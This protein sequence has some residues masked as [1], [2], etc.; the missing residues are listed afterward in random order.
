MLA[1]EVANLTDLGSVAVAARPG[2][3]MLAG[4]ETCYIDTALRGAD[5]GRVRVMSVRDPARATARALFVAVALA[6][7]AAPARVQCAEP[8]ASLG[9]AAPKRFAIVIGNGDYR[10]A[11]DLR[12]A[13]AD[14]RL[15][16]D[17][18]AG[19]GYAVARIHDLDKA[20][21]E[22]M[23]QRILFEF[24]KD[25]EVVFYF[26]GHGVQIA[27]DNYLIPTDAALD[28]PYDLPFEAVSL[29]T[30]VNV[31]GA[32]ARTQ[33]VILDS[34]RANP[35]G[36]AAV[37]A[38]ISR[39]LSETGDGFNVL[40][41]PMNSLLAFSTSPGAN[42]W[43]GS[44]G[45]SPFTAALVETAREDAGAADRSDFRSGTP[46]GLQRTNGPQVPWESSTLVQSVAFG[47]P[48][49]GFALATGDAPGPGAGVPGAPTMPQ[50]AVTTPRRPAPPSAAA[51]RAMTARRDMESSG[52]ALVAADLPPRRRSPDPC[53]PRADG[54]CSS[55]GRSP[56]TRA[57]DWA[58]RAHLYPCLRSARPGR[59]AR[60]S[61]GRQRQRQLHHHGQRGC[62]GGRVDPRDRS[63][64]RRGRRPPRPRGR[65]PRLYPNEIVPEKALPACL[66]AVERFPDVGRFRYQLG[67]AQLAMRDFDAAKASF[68]RARDLGHTR[69]WVALGLLVATADARSRGSADAPVPDEAL[70]LY[71][72][73]V[74]AGDPYAIHTLGRELLRHGPDRG[75][76]ARGLPAARAGGR[77]RAYLLDERAWRLLSR[78]RFSDADPARGLRYIRKFG[79]R[80]ATSMATTT[81]ASSI[82]TGSPGW[83]PTRAAVE[84]FE[85]AAAGGHPDAPGT[86]GRLWNS[87]QLGEN[88]R[89][90]R[91][92]EWYD[93]GLARCDGWSGTNAAWI[94]VNRAPGDFTPRDAAVR[95]AKAAVLN[96][97]DSATEAQSLLATLDR[98]A[99]DG[100][101]Q[102]LVNALGGTIVVD[103]AFGPASATEMA[104]VLAAV[105]MPVPEG[106]PT[107][108]LLGLARVYWR[109][110]PCRVD[111]Y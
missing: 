32:R 9:E 111:L 82:A 19:Q 6:I 49:A 72:K 94:I 40:T 58:D 12:N 28:D 45:N 91:A 27:G 22:A 70:A 105:G 41:A 53:R 1:L 10:I 68:E 47:V 90:A 17:F 36:G 51:D 104:R 59:G 15:V 63:L 103:G 18:L 65:R 61:P 38:D 101:A 7:A 80:A 67:R 54:C 107:E 39:T 4:R 13:R 5:R 60:L 34:C 30:I 77:G 37:L 50:A 108:R 16:A 62:R 29:T 43:D 85:K 20:G 99:I 44:D 76:A 35:F 109:V 81:S 74:D 21:F 33:I 31:L 86:L 8:P 78:P 26:A 64:R 71:Q 84:W 73:G 106:T 110:E 2:I 66:A 69:A 89:Y 11:P 87:G 57:P 88:D 95:A 23:L 24:D 48:S 52:P 14:A 98:P 92:V 3:G 25:S 102:T 96:G 97:E 79:R 56:R 83:R 46:A 100:A 75:D 93:Q 42:A 55:L